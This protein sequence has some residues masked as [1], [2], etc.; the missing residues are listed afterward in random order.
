[1]AEDWPVVDVWV[2]RSKREIL[3]TDCGG[4]PAS[5]C[6]YVSEEARAAAEARGWAAVSEIGFAEE[7]HLGWFEGEYAWKKALELARHKAAGLGYRVV[8]EDSM[9]PP[10][11][12][13]EEG[14]DG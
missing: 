12:D 10:N 1:M 7:D 2:L 9:F 5:I 4:V 8:Q 11:S 3:V 14:D 6:G 13:W